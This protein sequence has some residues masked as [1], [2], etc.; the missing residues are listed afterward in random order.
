MKR[1]YKHVQDLLDAAVLHQVAT[2]HVDNPALKQTIRETLS[3]HLTQTG[4]INVPYLLDALCGTELSSAK[5]RL[6]ERGDIEITKGNEPRLVSELSPEDA[7]FIDERRANHIK[8]ELETRVVFNHRHGRPEQAAEANCQLA[9]FNKA[10]VG[11]EE[12]TPQ[13]QHV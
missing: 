12:P 1:K 5:Q 6:R 13:P 8:G 3:Y 2:G 10:Q 11:T 4:D 7:A 9:L